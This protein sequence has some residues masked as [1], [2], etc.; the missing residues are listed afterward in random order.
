MTNA[1][2]TSV[3]QRSHDVTAVTEAVTHSRV[4]LGDRGRVS[5]Y[6]RDSGKRHA[7][8]AARPTRLA[9][10]AQPQT[11]SA[12]RKPLPILDHLVPTAVIA[13]ILLAHAIVLCK[14]DTG[15]R[16]NELTPS[17]TSRSHRNF[18]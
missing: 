2:A 11:T 3:T 15:L 10:N 8:D 9:G 14:I 7:R 18:W 6:C 13:G 16:S 4:D 12:V 5:D 1:T 17:V